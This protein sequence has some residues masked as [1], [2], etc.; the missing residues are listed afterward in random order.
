MLPADGA[1]MGDG[2]RRTVGMAGQAAGNIEIRVVAP[3]RLHIGFLDLNGG[4]GR[5]FGSLG[6]A[7]DQ[8]AVGLSLRRQRQ[9]LVT[10]CEIARARR[11]L[12]SAR[13]ALGA[14]GRHALR[15]DEVLP[16]HAG[17]GSGT[18]LAL[19]IA[20]AV[21]E[22]EGL[23]FDPAAV[24]SR[25]DRGARS[26]IG[27]G[28]FGQGGFVVDGGKGGSDRSPPIVSRLAFP[29]QWRILLARDR[30]IDG[31]HGPEEKTAFAALPEFPAADAA[32]M[33]RLVM[34]QM[35]PALAEADIV[36]FGRAVSRLQ[37]RLGDHFAPAQGGGRYTSARV[38]RAMAAAADLGAAGIGQSSWGPT[39]FALYGSEAAA[40]SAA[41]VLSERFGDEEGLNFRVVAGRNHGATITRHSVD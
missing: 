24:S 8:P 41:A 25:L 26:G 7:I 19:A 21:A 9:D 37:A 5:R 34:M 20:A 33:C 39:G 13:D 2:Q 17:F 22:L 1:A 4:L 15:I 30:S 16:A 23:A 28:A 18:Q 11:Y 35:L 12:D 31:V 14:R 40:R 29:G 6:L 32:E 10:G 3:A 36:G 27:I 38:G